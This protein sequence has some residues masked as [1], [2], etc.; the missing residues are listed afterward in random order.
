MS[1]EIF[2]PRRVVTAEDVLRLAR[3]GGTELVVGPDDRMTALARDT[4]RDKKVSVVVRDG[5]PPAWPFALHARAAAPG[6]SPAGPAPAGGPGVPQPGARGAANTGPVA[7]IPP[8]PPGAPIATPVPGPQPSAPPPRPGPRAGAALP[9]LTHVRDPRRLAL[10]PFPDEAPA[11]AMDVRVRDIVTARDG[12][13]MGVGLMSLRE[14]SFA[15]HLDYDE[16]EYVLEGELHI[17][18]A[19]E[20]VVGLPGDVIAVPCGSQIT[21]GT[22]TWAKFLYVT[23]PADWSGA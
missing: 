20:K 23:Y 1:D 19:L 10:D 18:T 22:P 13:S 15:W 8:S 2:V 12:V 17:T 7:P 9:R 3:S 4:A 11:Q 5:A 6:S 21:F 14:G 16:I